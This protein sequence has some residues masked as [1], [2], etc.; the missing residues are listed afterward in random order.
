MSLEFFE[1]LFKI[2]RG[3]NSLDPFELRFLGGA[4]KPEVVGVMLILFPFPE[5]VSYFKKLETLSLLS[6]LNWGLAMVMYYPTAFSFCFKYPDRLSLFPL[7]SIDIKLFPL[8]AF[9]FYASAWSRD[10]LYTFSVKPNTWSAILQV[11]FGY[12]IA[13]PPGV[14][15]GVMW[16]ALLFVI[17]V[18]LLLLVVYWE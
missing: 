12:C 17:V 9:T 7:M 4:S 6:F 1:Q 11:L 2:I 10:H 14:L 13:T 3:L 15:E 8:G 16:L 5:Q 18:L